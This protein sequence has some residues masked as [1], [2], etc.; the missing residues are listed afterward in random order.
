MNAPLG[1]TNKVYNLMDEADRTIH[2]SGNKK[3]DIG[4]GP[5]R[6]NTRY[7]ILLTLEELRPFL[8]KEKHRDFIVVYLEK[9][10]MTDGYEYETIAAEQTKH[11]QDLGYER[12]VV[13]GASAMGI[14][15]IADTQLDIIRQLKEE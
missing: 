9:F 1:M 10:A 5:I 12:V 3:Y 7:P 13:L 2:Y 11:M 15:Y 14:H 6:G 8:A 4:L